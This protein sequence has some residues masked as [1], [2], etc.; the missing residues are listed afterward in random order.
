MV[1]EGAEVALGDDL[2]KGGEVGEEVCGF[3]AG[4]EGWRGEAAEA[5]VGGDEVGEDLLAVGEV[6]TVAE[7]VGGLEGE[8]RAVEVVVGEVVCAEVVE[9]LRDAAV[10]GG[11]GATRVVG[12]LARKAR[13]IGNIED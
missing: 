1:A 5:D 2:A 6:E 8:L 9:I 12:G 13:A 10:S 7:V 11:L 3:R 4:E